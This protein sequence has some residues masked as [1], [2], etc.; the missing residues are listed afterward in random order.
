M[1]KT[2]KQAKASIFKKSAKHSGKPVFGYDFNQ[3][4]DFKKFLESFSHTGFQATNLGKAIEIAKKMQKDNVDIFLGATS[5]Q[6][7]SG[8]REAIRY[9]AEHK[10]VK[11]LV[12]TTGAVE[13]DIIKTKFDFLHGDFRAGGAKLRAK[14]INRIG[15]IFV[16]NNRY[17]WFEKFFQPILSLLREKQRKEGKIFSPSEIISLM[18]KKI[19]D[20]SSICFW[21]QKNNIPIFCP[22]FMD[23]A[24]GDNVFFFNYGKAQELK[25]DQASDHHKLIEMTLDAKET[26]LIILGAGVVKHT[27]CNANMFR[28]GTKYAIYLNTAIEQ[29]G[30]D[31]GAE[32][33]EAKSWGKISAKAQTVKVFGDTTINF[34]LLVAGAFA[35]K[36]K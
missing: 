8:N 21:A 4:L 35:D 11:A 17:I 9:L 28:E 26:G 6:V 20:E 22:A 14:G 15:N 32:P 2:S 23:G 12:V 5:N 10:L 24:V 25:V 3:G 36:K 31:S 1:K 30:S 33:E 27:L 29:D 13:E 19:N 34:P 7:S 16:P 18:G